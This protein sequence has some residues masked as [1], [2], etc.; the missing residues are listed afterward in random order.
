MM[1]TR[2]T[3]S[4]ALALMVG[5]LVAS[6]ALAQTGGGYD[7]TWH[8]VDGGGGTVSGGNFTLMGT[9][10]QPEP[11]PALTGGSYTLY[12]GFWP[13]SGEAPPSPD[14]HIYLPLVLRDL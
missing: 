13:A 7:L 3:L 5:L 4:L 2:R 6:A 12:S 9:A 14:R 1:N 11:G 8:T 10:G